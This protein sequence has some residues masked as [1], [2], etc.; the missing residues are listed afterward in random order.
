MISIATMLSH[1]IKI[2]RFILSEGLG[3]WLRK[4]GHLRNN[5]H[6]NTH[7]RDTAIGFI[8]LVVAVAIAVAGAVEGFHRVVRSE[9]E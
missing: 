1:L 8:P 2:T 5:T 4:Y 7:T 6:T 9:S 3:F